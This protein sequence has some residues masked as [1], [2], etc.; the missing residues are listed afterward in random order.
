MV[1]QYW[2]DHV[3]GSVADYVRLVEDAKA[4]GLPVL[5]GLEMDW[6]HGK[7]DVLRSFL[8]PYDWDIVLGSVHYIGSWGIDDDLFIDEWEKRDVAE[9]WAEYGGADEGA[10]GIGPGRR[11]DAPGRGEE[12]RAPPEGRDA[13]ARPDPRRA[14]P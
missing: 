5:L 1:G 6:L 10:G 7:E 11:A 4:A 13:A 9:A 2:Q 8:A 3:S 12:V 14:R